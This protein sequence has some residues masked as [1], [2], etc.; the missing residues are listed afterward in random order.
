ML[1][2]HCL[3]IEKEIQK[4]VAHDAVLKAKLANLISIPGIAMMTAICSVSETNGFTLI[5]NA[6][7]LASYAGLDVVHN[8]SGIKQGKP[9]RSKIGNKFIRHALYMPSLSAINYNPYM[10]A[11]FERIT[12][13]R[14]VKK[15]GMR[16]Q[17]P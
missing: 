3:L 11:F 4:I 14:P 16:T 15:I 7:Q 12:K 9:K 5:R 1:E 13:G 6:K 17:L 10:K 2:K 8:Q